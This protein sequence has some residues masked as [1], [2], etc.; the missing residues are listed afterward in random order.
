MRSGIVSL[1]EPSAPLT[2]ETDSGYWP[3][4]RAKEDCDYQYSN[5]DHDKPR[6]TLR[7][8]VRK[9]PTP[10]AGDYKAGM[11]NAPNRQQSSLPRSLALEAGIVSGGRGGP[12]PLWVEWLMGWPMGWTAL[13][14]LATDKFQQ[15]C[16]AHGKSSRDAA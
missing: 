3:T 5:G 2:V 1:R 7:G 8:A 14:P 4:P 16:D 11:S 12:N 10:N 9:W 15:W 6:L 13:A